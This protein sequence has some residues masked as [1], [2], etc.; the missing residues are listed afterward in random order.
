MGKLIEPD[1]IIKAAKLNKIGGAST[2][3]ILMIL[4]RI[5]KI[6]KLYSE[7][8][9]SR[10]IEF[11]DRLIKKLKITYEVSEEEINRIP[12][13]GPFITVSNHPYGGI[14]GM[15]MVK[16]INS[17]RSDYKVMAN[18]LLQRVDSIDEFILPVNPFEDRKSASSS[19]KGIKYALKHLQDGNALG[20]FPAGEVSSYN[21]HS[22]GISDKQWQEPVLKMIKKAQVPVVPIYFTGNNSRL[23][24]LLGIIHPS[25]RTV[26]LP[27]E[28]FNKKKKPI[29][30]RIGNPIS[31][32]EQ[33]DFKDIQRYGRFLRA[34]TYAL[35]SA[36]EV[37]KFFRPSISRASK[38]EDI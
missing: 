36:L 23:F 16:V 25:L 17:V 5:N 12:K 14:D 35:G 24:H 27:S 10:G 26:R 11:I 28:L 8:E 33:N 9:K 34:K 18:F 15:L 38:V 3:R 21:I 32:K 22:V 30:I 1:D 29:R 2:A 6:N 37:H 20:I 31:V 19:L 4:L 7:L 13:S